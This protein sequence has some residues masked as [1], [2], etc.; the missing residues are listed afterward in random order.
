V[1]WLGRAVAIVAAV[2]TMGGCSLVAGSRPQLPLGT[3][4]GYGQPYQPCTPGLLPVPLTQ[5]PTLSQAFDSGDSS[6]AE[7]AQL[8]P[9]APSEMVTYS[10]HGQEPLAGATNEVT[11]PP[12]GA[13][14]HT[15]AGVR[16]YVTLGGVC[17][18]EWRVSAHPL[19]GFDGQQE[20]GDS[21][22]ELGSGSGPGDA[23]VVGGVYAGEW[24]VHIHLVFGTVGTTERD[25]TDSY[26]LVITTAGRQP[27]RVPPPDLVAPC[28]DGIAN[29][30]QAPEMDLSTD[31]VSWT[32]GELGAR[33]ES[34]DTTLDKPPVPVISVAAGSLIRVRTADGSCGND[35]GGAM[36]APVPVDLGSVFAGAGLD[37][38]NGGPPDALTPP[39]VGGLNAVAPA[40]GEWLFSILFYF[41]ASAVANYYWRLSAS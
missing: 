38:N 1:R 40:R 12:A 35:W 26:A 41:G 28:G 30:D 5:G 6:P 27:A 25:T 29:L 8:E 3:A 16:L 19:A 36:F 23:V 11:V 34:G 39:V 24:I 15:S 22:V 7:A 9:A 17:I 33:S 10:W 2:A 20:S 31:G 21:W 32:A 4:R 13:A 14:L 18:A 37:D